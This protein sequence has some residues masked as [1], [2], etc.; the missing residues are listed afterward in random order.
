[1]AT[2]HDMGFSCISN[3]FTINYLYPKLLCEVQLNSNY[4]IDQSKLVAISTSKLFMCKAK[5]EI[6]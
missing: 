2:H 6:W 5:L 1:M 4:Q 3:S